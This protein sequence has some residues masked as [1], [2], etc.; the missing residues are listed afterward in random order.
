M[1]TFYHLNLSIVKI[2]RNRFLLKIDKY[3]YSFLGETENFFYKMN[4]Q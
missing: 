4:D 1:K 2:L 3:L